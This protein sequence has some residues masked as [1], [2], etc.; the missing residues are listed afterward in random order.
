MASDGAAT[1]SRRS[2]RFSSTQGIYFLRLRE[3][4]DG[5]APKC[6][7]GVYAILSLSKTSSNP[8]RLFFGCPF[9]KGRL[10]HCK[11]FMWLDQY[12]AKICT[13]EAGNCGEVVEDVTE[14]FSKIKYEWRLY[15]LEKRVASLEQ[16]KKNM[17]LCYVMGLCLF[18]VAVYVTTR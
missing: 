13:I 9:F 2:E 1:S 16:R 11:F 12:T 3:E 18:L 8:N 4:M 5:V 14:H 6:R 17:Y 10:P 7:C 15:E